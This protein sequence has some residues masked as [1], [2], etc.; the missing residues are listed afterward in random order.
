MVGLWW[1]ESIQPTMLYPF[2]TK[3]FP[4]IGLGLD[5]FSAKS[6]KYSIRPCRISSR[7]KKNYW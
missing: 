1:V 5:H 6:E 2:G 4:Y 7:P 3:A